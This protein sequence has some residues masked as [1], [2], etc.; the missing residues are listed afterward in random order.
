MKIKKVISNLFL[1]GRVRQVRQK[2]FVGLGYSKGSRYSKGSGH[3]PFAKSEDER[4][5]NSGRAHMQ[6]VTDPTIRD[7]SVTK[8]RCHANFPAGVYCTRDGFIE[9]APV[10]RQAVTEIFI[11]AYKFVIPDVHRGRVRAGARCNCNH[12]Q[13]HASTRAC[14]SPIRGKDGQIRAVPVRAD[15]S[16]GQRETVHTRSILPRNRGMTLRRGS[17]HLIA[18]AAATAGEDAG[19][20]SSGRSRTP[21]ARRCARVR[22]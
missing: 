13:A 16:P 4:S 10:S 18:T 15:P 12:A 8:L 11:P 7:A 1:A 9:R 14:Q 5:Y 2:R 17:P 19:G 3:S 22:D 20:C 21:P 6:R